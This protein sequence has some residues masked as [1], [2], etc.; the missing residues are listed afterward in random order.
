MRRAAAA[1][2]EEGVPL[3]FAGDVYEVNRGGVGARKSLRVTLSVFLVGLAFLVTLAFFAGF[4]IG[5]QNG[6]EFSRSVWERKRAIARV[7]SQS[8]LQG[9]EQTTLG[10]FVQKRLQSP[11]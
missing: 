6:E 8:K 3:S 5:A 7:S 11:G 1:K 4:A 2:G 10:E 9:A